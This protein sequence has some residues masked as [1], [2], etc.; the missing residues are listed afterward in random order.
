RQRSGHAVVDLVQRWWFQVQHAADGSGKTVGQK[1]MLATQHLVENQAQGEKIG[2]SVV[3]FLLQDLGGHVTRR[4]AGRDGHA[5]QT[6]GRFRGVGAR[7]PL[8]YTEVENLYS[9]PGGQHDVF[10]LDISVHDVPLV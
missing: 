7:K 3:D 2:A 4:S 8:S 9:L 1:G 5:G 10:G 6:L